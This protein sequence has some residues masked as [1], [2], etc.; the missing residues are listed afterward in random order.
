MKKIVLILIT[1][2][3]FRTSFALSPG[4]SAFAGLIPGL[5][6]MLNGQIVEGIGWMAFSLGPT[7]TGDY[8]LGL[9]GQ[10]IWFYSIYDTWRDAG[11]SP[12]QKN[13]V[14]SDYFEN[15]NP[16]NLFDPIGASFIGTAAMARSSARRNVQDRNDDFTHRVANTEAWKSIGMFTF[17]GLGEEALFRG[18]LFP[19][20]SGPLV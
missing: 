5:G 10:N 17:V 1:S 9:V 7:A 20:L 4:W 8:K 16:L 19:A 15:F 11:G 13:W 2:L 18:F 14:A 3:T 6:H 12:S